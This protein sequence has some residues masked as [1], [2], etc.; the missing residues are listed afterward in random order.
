M[1][2]PVLQ[3]KM[4]MPVEC[5]P[6]LSFVLCIH[7]CTTCVHMSM[8][9]RTH[10]KQEQNQNKNK[11]NERKDGLPVTNLVYLVAELSVLSEVGRIS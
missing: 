6:M 1:R 9:A 8:R 4:M 11:I 5:Q 7:T 2:G 10:T 3:K